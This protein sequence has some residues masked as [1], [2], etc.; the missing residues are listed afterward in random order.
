[1]VRSLINN[2]IWI[3]QNFDKLLPK[4]YR[5][6]GN[7]D[8]SKSLVPKYLKENLII[9]DIG[10]GK[11]P[12][13]SP[14]KKKTLNATVIGLDIDKEELIQAPEGAYNKIICA[15]ITKFRGN[16]DADL[17]LCQALLEHVKDVEAAFTA[18]SSILKPGGLA[19]IFVPSRNAV[20]ARLNIIL[21]QSIKKA[22][23]HTIYP[24]TKRGQGFP[25]YYNRCTPSEFKKLADNSDF[26]IQEEHYYFISSYFN[27]FFPAYLV[28]RLW[29]LL[30]HSVFKEQAAETFSLVLRKGDNI[31]HLAVRK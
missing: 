23:L 17:V 28:W 16:H 20:F 21:P 30:F 18:I 15:D 6:D 3:S 8:Y 7:R 4:K 27:F 13:L 1:M 11:N 14:D 9:Y 10:G 31:M 19:L 12:Y 29:I 22:I 5:L 24:K 25:S 2:Q 26:S